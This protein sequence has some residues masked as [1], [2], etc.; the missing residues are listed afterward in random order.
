MYS[1]VSPQAILLKVIH[2]NKVVSLTEMQFTCTGNMAIHQSSRRGNC[3]E[4]VTSM[5]IAAVGL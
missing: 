4:C 1:L 5:K 3:A 2:S